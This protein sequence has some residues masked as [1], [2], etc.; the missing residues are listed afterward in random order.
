MF[1]WNVHCYLTFGWDYHTTLA[2]IENPWET[3]EPNLLQQS[4]LDYEKFMAN[5]LSYKTYSKELIDA[6]EA[7][8]T[9]FLKDRQPDVGGKGVGMGP[10]LGLI[11]CVEQAC[12]PGT[13]GT[14]DQ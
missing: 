12:S 10:G 3:A 13:P 8:A 2:S 4:G 14:T 6:S 9:P 1:V 11:S 7:D 5:L